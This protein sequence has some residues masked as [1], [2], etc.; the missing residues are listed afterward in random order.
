MV[1]IS[2]RNLPNASI[3]L[4]CF[5][6]CVAIRSTLK[7]D[8]QSRPK[9]LQ[10]MCRYHVYAEDGTAVCR[11]HQEEDVWESSAEEGARLQQRW[12]LAI[13]RCCTY[14]RGVVIGADNRILTTL[15]AATFV[16]QWMWI[17]NTFF[18]EHLD[19]REP[20]TTTLENMLDHLFRNLVYNACKY[21]SCDST[22]QIWQGK[23]DHKL[24]SLFYI[25]HQECN[26]PMMATIN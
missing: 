21:R 18:A 11:W 3:G 4:R 19:S 17:A 25:V 20:H 1:I 2:Y 12:D 8:R 14:I 13:Q 9:M 6:V 7:M 24:S 10:R 22:V 5:S 15:G 23:T 16:L 26:R